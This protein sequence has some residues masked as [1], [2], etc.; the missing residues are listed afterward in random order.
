MKYILKKPFVFLL[1]IAARISLYRH[2]PIVIAVTG[3][4]GKT[5]TKEVI[6]HLL[7]FYGPVR[8]SPKSFN[9]DTGIPLTILDLPTGWNS[10]IQ[11]LKILWLSYEQAF[12]QQ[13][14]PPYLI[15]EVGADFPGDI[16][17]VSR[18]LRT[19]I[20]VINRFS[21]VP[22]HIENFESREQLVDEKKSILRSLKPSG[23]LVMCAD[24]QDVATFLHPHKGKVIDFGWEKQRTVRIHPTVFTYTKKHVSGVQVCISRHPMM[25][26]Y[27]L[28]GIA[29]VH[30]AEPV[31]AGIAVVEALGLDMMR[32]PKQPFENY[33]FIQ[34]RMRILEGIKSTTIIDD[35]YNAAPLAM[36]AALH[37]LSEIK[38][39]RKIAIIGDMLE[40]GSQSSSEHER[41]AQT[42]KDI[43]DVVVAVGVRSKIYADIAKKHNIPSYHFETSVEA[44]PILKGLLES[45]DVVLVKGSQGVRMERI[46]KEI[47]KDTTVAHELLVRQDEEW[48]TR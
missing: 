16:Q 2:K 30:M 20:V 32:I 18:W 34:G 38:A 14:Y 37:S 12:F 3:N 23:V 9:S 1:T 41:I 43:A 26:A 28:P 46:V 22:V 7:S 10:I 39:K 4:I 29:G 48:L 25:F 47:L 17:G 15:L 35:T 36:D 5:S 44:I 8:K 21:P 40:L 19:D 6:A 11:W 42:A 31:A 45:G 27:N 13:H 33:Q 24:D